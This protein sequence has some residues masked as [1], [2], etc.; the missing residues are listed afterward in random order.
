M[1]S[2]KS[3]GAPTSRKFKEMEGKVVLYGWA[4]RGQA[5]PY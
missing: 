5:M 4:E 3:A 1:N 2:P